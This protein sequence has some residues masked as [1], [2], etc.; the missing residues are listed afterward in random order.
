MHE[1][2][3]VARMLELAEETARS[4]GA[5]TIHK[6]GLRIGALSAVVPEALFFAFEALR[7]GTM[8]ENAE[9]EVEWIPVVAYCEDCDLEF[10]TDDRFGIYLCPHCGEPTA[11]MRRGDELEISFLEVA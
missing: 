4:Q 3:I 10:E 9:L 11:E 7:V 8:A 5:R 1:G 6:I 2:G